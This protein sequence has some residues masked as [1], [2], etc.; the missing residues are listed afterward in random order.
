MSRRLA[1]V[2][3]LACAVVMGAPGGSTVAVATANEAT[4]GGEGATHKGW[5]L[6]YRESFGKP[7]PDDAPWFRDDYSDPVDPIT[8]DNGDRWRL[9]WGPD[10]DAAMDTFDTY[11][12]E[13]E[14]GRDGWLTASLSA[15]DS[16]GRE[17]DSFSAPDDRPSISNEA[18]PGAGRVAAIDVPKHTGGAIIRSTEPLPR[19]YRI[20]Y[21]LKTLDFGGE[22]NGSINYDGKVNGYGTEGCKTFFPWPDRSPALD[23][24][25]PS[26][27]CQTDSVREGSP[28]AYNAFHMLS[29][30]DVPPMPRNLA[31]YHWHR[32]VLIDQFA[33]APSRDTRNYLVCN[34]DT[35]E[36]YPFDESN[37]TTVNML[38]FNGPLG[39]RQ[40][41]VSSC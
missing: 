31:L 13:S 18:L 40:T 2:M 34:S 11:R 35:G 39:Q 41:F 28:Q 7:I 30:L 3:A 1:S 26:D 38:F 21:D 4:G 19:Y 22:R 37:R 32:K 8:D 25:V 24:I 27:P 29:I 16:S 15:R 9:R 14:F 12:K 23:P 33:P 5:R 20:E 10:F 36:Y 6:K 17:D